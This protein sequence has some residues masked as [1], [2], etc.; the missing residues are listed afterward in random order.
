[1][2]DLSVLV[3]GLRLAAPWALLGWLALPG[4]LWLTR[5]RQRGGGGLTFPTAAWFGGLR[6]SP[7]AR[8]SGLPDWLRAGVLALAML[9]LARPQL[10][11][12]VQSAPQSGVDV[13]LALDLSGSMMAQDVKPSRADA[14]CHTLLKFL[15]RERNDRVGLVVFAGRSFTAVPLTTDYEVLSQMVKRCHV[16]MV[17]EGGTAIGD[18]LGNCLYRLL[19]PDQRRRVAAGLPP[20]DGPPQSRVIILLTDGENNS[21]QLTPLEAAEMVRRCGVRIHCIGLGSLTGAHIPVAEGGRQQFMMHGKDLLLT[22][23]NETELRQIAAATG[24]VFHRATDAETLD[25]IY[26]QIGAME[27]H[28]VGG[29]KVMRHEE[30]FAQ[31]LLAAV[32]LLLAEL[33]LRA[34]W[35]R[36]EV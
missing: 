21:G 25:S 36:V 12:E 20:D 11:V 27:R 3:P 10:G 4:W 33:L 6:P 34:T 22:R 13:M 15:A 5:R 16:G 9:A 31:M 17:T 28:E 2:L 35:L 23:L 26:Q 7:R 32:A 19:S 14:A 24:G 8:L 18:A 30:R 1:M 29:Q